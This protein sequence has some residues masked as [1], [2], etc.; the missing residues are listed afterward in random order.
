MGIRELQKQKIVAQERFHAEVARIDAE[1]EQIR[2]KR[3]TKIK[4]PKWTDADTRNAWVA[5]GRAR[6]LN[7]HG[8]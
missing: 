1:I 6:Q 4:Q 3:G 5:E 8:A 2:R 7:P